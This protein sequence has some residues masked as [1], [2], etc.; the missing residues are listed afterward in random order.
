MSVIGAVDDVVDDDDQ[1]LKDSNLDLP[2]ASLA[3]S[4]AAAVAAAAAAA[5]A[6]IAA[7]APPPVSEQQARQALLGLVAERFCWG[8]GAARSMRITK[9][10]STSA[11]HVNRFNYQLKRLIFMCNVYPLGR[12]T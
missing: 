9:I 4:S 5:A 1:L 11:F 12:C 6:Q 3:S 7:H 2:S 10:I 8:G